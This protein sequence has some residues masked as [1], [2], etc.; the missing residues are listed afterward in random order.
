[1]PIANQ[2]THQGC[3][4]TGVCLQAGGKPE[5]VKIIIRPERACLYSG[6]A[7]SVADC[8]VEPR[9][10]GRFE[11]T[12]PPSSYAG[13]YKVFMGNAR[14]QMTVPEAAQAQFGQIAGVI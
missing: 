3:K 7:Y 10:D 5:S 13:L 11:V 4:I 9:A 1:M 14:F 6:V 2:P 8:I 12:L